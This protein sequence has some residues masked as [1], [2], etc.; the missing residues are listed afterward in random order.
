V[1][2]E[3]PGRALADE[4]P[5]YL[6]PGHP[7]SDLQARRA[8]DL[9]PLAAQPPSVSDLLALL[10]SPNLCDRRPVWLQYDHMNGTNT[11]VGPGEGDAALLR[12]KGTQRA[13]AL[14]LDGPGVVAAL[15]PRLAA[16]A[17][18]L[19]SAMNVAVSGARPIGLTNCLNFP[20]PETPE[21]YWQLSEAVAGL[22]AGA[23]ALDIPIVSGNV[24][25]YNETPDGPILPAPL[26]GMVGLLDDRSLVVPMRWH[27]GDELWLLGDPAQDPASLAGSELAVA[28]GVTG[29]RPSLAVDAAAAVVKLLPRLAQASLLS[30]AHDVARGGLAVALA[31]MAIASELGASVELPAGP[32]TAVLFG[33]RVGRAVLSVPTSRVGELRSLAGDLPLTR[34]GFAGGTHLRITATRRELSASVSAMR[35]AWRTALEGA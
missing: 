26:V 3:V 10:A 23:R 20:S 5:T 28:R 29:G 30:G 27:D 19:E 7:P 6:R 17:A 15:D 33:E 9:A 11:L 12:I 32:S 1:V 16:T 31:R 34:L 14:A 4:A 21:G 8:Q 13:L 25:L 22:A 18:V 2:C 24:S 35:T